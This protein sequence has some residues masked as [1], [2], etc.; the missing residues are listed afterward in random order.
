MTVDARLLAADL[1]GLGYDPVPVLPGTKRP[2]V[3]GYAV[4]PAPVQWG[5]VQGAASVALRGGGVAKAGFLDC[6]EDE[7]PGTVDNAKRYLGGLGYYPDGSYPIV[8]T[9]SQVGRHFY[10]SFVGGLPGHSRLLHPDFGKGEFRYGPAA[11]VVA[12]GG[13][14]PYTLL[15]GDLRQLPK[16]EVADVLPILMNQDAGEADPAAA[17]LATAPS[18]E[19]GRIGRATWRLMRGEGCDRYQ[20]RSEAEMAIVDGLVNVGLSFGAILGLFQ[21]WPCAGKFTEKQG[22]NP[23]EAI[24]YLRLTWENAV[25]WTRTH[26]SEGRKH[27]FWAIQWAQSRPW[28]G[29]TGRTEH[30]CFLVHALTAFECGK[31]EYNLSERELA[32]RAGVGD[33]TAHKGNRKLR[34]VGFIERVKRTDGVRYA[35]LWRLSAESIAY[36]HVGGCEGM[37]QLPHSG[38]SVPPLAHDA[39]RYRGLGKTAFELLASLR[40]RPM[41]A[42]ELCDVTGRK[43]RTV[44]DNLAKMARIVDPATGEVFHL[45]E[46][47]GDKWRALDADLD[48]IARAKGT[49]GR[50]AKQ[51]REHELQRQ[52]WHKT[53]ERQRE[54]RQNGQR[55]NQGQD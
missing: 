27:A 54:E 45:V 17:I 37:H 50:G 24:R 26:A 53:I 31:L 33:V 28:P 34:D 13:D 35:T 30:A 10:V 55:S 4:M 11:I 1:A 43:R 52:G 20:S 42:N 48:A 46:K 44:Y 5:Q 21:R 12:P 49:A 40:V 22:E 16:L 29:S 19:P 14:E 41:T 23:Q 18:G 9:S 25:K 51:R 39:F 47:D 2:M 8:Q 7:R 15:E 38:D 32:E 6:D 36:P 3:Q